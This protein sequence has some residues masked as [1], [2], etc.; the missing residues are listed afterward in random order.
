[1]YVEYT[2]PSSQP[3]YNTVTLGLMQKRGQG[4][5]SDTLRALVP[6]DRRL[7]LQILLYVACNRRACHIGYFACF[8]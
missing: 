7:N 4:R 6:F 3:S 2:Q 5:V 1:M 8:L